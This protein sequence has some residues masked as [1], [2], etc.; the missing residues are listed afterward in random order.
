MAASS[1]AAATSSSFVAV[2]PSYRVEFVA[3]VELLE[4][5]L[6]VSS[7]LPSLAE[8]VGSSS[9]AFAAASSWVD[10][11]VLVVVDSAAAADAASELLVQPSEPPL[12]AGCLVK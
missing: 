11:G 5:P 8:P 12:V 4:C 10:F 6:L 9:F 2:E 7:E 3:A 1:S